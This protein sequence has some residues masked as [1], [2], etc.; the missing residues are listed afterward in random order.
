VRPVN[1]H[2]AAISASFS[3]QLVLA[4]ASPRRR[5][6]FSRLRLPFE[7]RPVDVDENAAARDNPEIIAHR[8]ARTKAEAARLLDADSVIVAADTVV[9]LDG[10][11]LGKPTEAEE[12]RR[13]L[14]ALRA[15]QHDVVSAVAVMRAG[16]RAALIRHPVSHVLMRDY[17]D[18][19]IEASIERG[20]PFDKAGAYAIQDDEFQPVERYDGCYCNVVGLSLW[21]TIELLRKADFEIV[22]KLEQLLTQ[23]AACP[24]KLDNR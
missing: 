18:A 14:R 16:G 19:E 7:V 8:V 4:S 17:S 2:D 3:P 23:C 22:V 6:L 10:S 20:D 1:P 21:A 24:L 5:D 15:R 9:A 12:A 13:M 11:I